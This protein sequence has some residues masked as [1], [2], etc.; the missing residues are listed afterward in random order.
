MYAVQ[1]RI[2]KFDEADLGT[3]KARDTVETEENL[4][5]VIPVA[6]VI[7]HSGVEENETYFS[8]KADEIVEVNDG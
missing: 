5:C 7:K 1:K 2:W 8:N 6:G 3:P 4:E